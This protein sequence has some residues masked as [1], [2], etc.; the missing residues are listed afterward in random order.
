M[1]LLYVCYLTLDDPLTHTQVVAYLAGLAAAGHEVHLLTFEPGLTRARRRHWRHRMRDSGITWHGLRYHKRPSLPATIYDTFLGAAAIAMWSRVYRLDAVHARTHVPAAMALMARKLSRRPPALVFDIRGLMVEEYEEAGRWRPGGI[2]SRVTKAVEKAAIRN[3]ERIVILTE[4]AR[5]KLFDGDGDVAS[6][7]HVIPCCANLEQIETGRSARERVREELGLRDSTV[8]I[9]VGKFPSWSMPDAMAD[10]FATASGSMPALHFLI[11][12]Q[13]D[14]GLIR[15]ELERNDVD[16]SSYT[17]TSK[18][19]D[20]MGAYLAAGDFAITFIRAAPST[21]GQ[22]PTK[23][24]EY[25]GAG[26]PVV[27]S[28]GIG[29]V[30][31]LMSPDIGVRVA[32][33]S[34]RSYRE[35]ASAVGRLVSDT[36]TSE[37]CRTCAERR[38]SLE[39]V[40]IPRYLA[41]YEA[42]ATG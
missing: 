23:L 35:A 24:G 14:G 10:F 4:N 28:A 33:H 22:S 39:R 12:T 17:I 19:A 27:H 32:E 42:M 18:P 37:R 34:R 1:R 7:V 25:L 41:L 8:M 31:D 9:Y 13:G 29:D 5:R 16:A 6:R 21:V 15:R 2:P 11:L 3:A 40:G 36:A 30:D 26:L 20:E 38:L